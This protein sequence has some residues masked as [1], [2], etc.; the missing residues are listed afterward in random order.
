M[1]WCLG[2]FNIL[3]KFIVAE[4]YFDFTIWLLYMF[5]IAWKKNVYLESD[6]AY[7]QAVKYRLHGLEKE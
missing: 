4:I 3:Y 1:L 5:C 2:I 7:F 6:C